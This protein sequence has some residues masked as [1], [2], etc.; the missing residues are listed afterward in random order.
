[1]IMA[2]ITKKERIL[3]A[4]KYHGVKMIDGSTVDIAD[5]NN[6]AISA[7]KGYCLANGLQIEFVNL[8]KNN[9]VTRCFKD[10]AGTWITLLEHR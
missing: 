2:I 3:C 1:M 8:Y 6:D 5:N 10:C 7:F 9:L 4:A